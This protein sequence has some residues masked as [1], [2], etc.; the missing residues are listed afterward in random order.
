M[1]GD[2]RDGGSP[3]DPDLDAHTGRDPGAS[4][5]CGQPA[6]TLA[7]SLG[8]ALGALVRWV[9][10]LALPAPPGAFPLGTFLINV[11]GCLLM[12]V[13]VVC[14]TEAGGDRAGG[15]RA[16]GKHTLWQP[17]L[18][19]GVLGGFTTFSTFA[20]DGHQLL[21]GGHLVVAG[22]Y[23]AGTAV[24]AVAA[25]AVGLA[26]TRRLVVRSPSGAR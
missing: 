1:S 16:G 11:V 14:V 7:V 13:L 15:D 20:L 22:A 17:F 10:G 8:G 18:G 9:I 26:L 19:V 2:A 25:V 23:L 3:S 6:F 24:A 21:D 12:G 4:I 5:L